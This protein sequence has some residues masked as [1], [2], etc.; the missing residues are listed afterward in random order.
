MKLFMNI[1]PYAVIS[2]ETL[3][4]SSRNLTDETNL[5]TSAGAA[6]VIDYIINNCILAF[7]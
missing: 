7:V 2:I 3:L 6:G 1:T 4:F 5:R